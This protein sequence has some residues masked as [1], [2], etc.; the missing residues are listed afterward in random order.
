MVR[1]ASIVVVA[2]I[3]IAACAK[4]SAIEPVESTTSGATGPAGF[5]R[6]TTCT[7]PTG[8]PTATQCQPE[9]WGDHC[10]RFGET[11]A[12]LWWASGCVAYDVQKDGSRHVSY[13]V[14]A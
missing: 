10:G 11:N 6:K 12:P 5:C 8:Y 2:A 4:G 9:G 14:A 1:R 3:A 13:D 7:E